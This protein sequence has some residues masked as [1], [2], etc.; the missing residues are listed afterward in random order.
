T[1]GPMRVYKWSQERDSVKFLAIQK[2]MCDLLEWRRP[3]GHGQA[4]PGPDV[5]PQGQDD[6]QDRLGKQARLA[7]VAPIRLAARRKL[8]D[9]DLV[10]RV[11][12]AVV[13][14]DTLSPV[15]LYQVA[16][17]TANQ[18]AHFLATWQ[19]LL[20]PGGNPRSAYISRSKVGLVRMQAKPFLARRSGQPTPVWVA[21]TRGAQLRRREKAA[22][23]AAQSQQLYLAMRDFSYNPGENLEL[24][25]ALYDAH[26]AQFLSENFLVRIA[27]CGQSN[28]LTN[29]FTVF[30]DVGKPDVDRQVYLVVQV[31]RMGRL[32][33]DSKKGAGQG[34]RRPLACGVLEV[35]S[36]L[37][38]NGSGLNREMEHTIKLFV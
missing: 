2:V 13:D 27:K 21:P 11:E 4:D 14:P 6:R 20:F 32:Q 9:M 37:R 31:L 5:G 16:F 33:S 22:S 1:V 12:C 28:F 19:L 36:L 26:E 17:P 10:P 23:R 8:L 15:E 30:T 3:D 18:S 25:F 24:R 7:F 29:H 35:T 34:Y 38:E